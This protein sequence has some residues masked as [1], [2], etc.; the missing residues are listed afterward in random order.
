M[1]PIPLPCILHHIYQNQ[2]CAYFHINSM[3]LGKNSFMLIL[4]LLFRLQSAMAI[5]QKSP[6][7]S[8]LK[9]RALS[10]QRDKSELDVLS[11]SQSHEIYNYFFQNFCQLYFN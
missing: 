1:E 6:I 10:Y 5:L 9:P 3:N 8:I 7:P 2:N 11:G 4:F